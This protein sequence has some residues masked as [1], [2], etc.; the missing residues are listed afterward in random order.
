MISFKYRHPFVLNIIQLFCTVAFCLL[1]SVS[2]FAI[3]NIQRDSIETLLEDAEDLARQNYE[4]A[5]V[6][7]N[8]ALN[9]ARRIDDKDYIAESLVVI[10]YIQIKNLKTEESLKPIE[11][12]TSYSNLVGDETKMGLYDIWGEYCVNTGEYKNAESYYKKVLELAIKNNNLQFQQTAYNSL[13][14]LYGF[15]SEFEKE[16]DSYYKELAINEKIQDW[17]AVSLNLR[18]LAL[19]HV[20]YKKMDKAHEL[21]NQAI[22]LNHRTKDSFELGACVFIRAKIF[23]VENKVQDWGN[24]L[25]YALPMLE[26][27][28]ERRK[29]IECWSHI[30]SYYTKMNRLDS[31]EY[32]FNLCLKNEKFIERKVRPSFFNKLGQYYQLRGNTDNAIVA[33]TTSYTLAKE[34]QFKDNIQNTSWLLSELYNKIGDNTNAHKFLREAYQYQ[35]TLIDLR[36]KLN[37]SEALYKYDFERKEKEIQTLKLRQSRTTMLVL[38]AMFLLSLSVFGYILRQRTQHTKALV[39]KSQEIE[40]QNRRLED[41]NEILK[42]FAYISAH[43][44]KE[45]LRNISSFIGIIQKRYIAQLP[46][47]A[48]E[49]MTFV[50]QGVKR[51]E[52]LLG[53]LLQYATIIMDDNQTDDAINVTDIIRGV[54]QNIK[55]L[56]SDKKAILIY[57]AV[58]NAMYIK[59]FHLMQLLE[60]IIS[61]ALKFNQNVP[62]INIQFALNSTDII[63]SISDNGIGMKKEYADKVYKLFQKLDRK[64][65]ADASGVGL[66][67]CKTIVDKYNGSIWFEP[68]ERGGTTFF[69]SFPIQLVNNQ[70]PERSPVLEQA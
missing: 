4:E 18:N 19:S 34:G 63:L 14:V 56:I 66:T 6:S 13:G 44:L 9:I 31:A 36:N 64:T 59:R 29:V 47:E 28:N 50:N 30:A 52:N 7:A 53:A 51:M 65:N 25:F 70:K 26:K 22:A 49:Y 61:N 54:E 68:N 33:L 24:Q 32:Y 1:A 55:Y 41:T 58:P 16:L 3:P 38:V 62:N 60:H 12:A 8:H 2:I 46:I 23:S 67:I 57:S 21:I 27:H 69:V 37:L 43:D 15:T 48:Q 40:S 5:L 42:Q 35:D 10:A 20:Q 45:P 39:E 17:N 11:E